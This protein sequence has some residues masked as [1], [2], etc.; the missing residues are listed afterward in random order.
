MALIFSDAL[1]FTMPED[2][3]TISWAPLVR[4]LVALQEP[5]I[6]SE[7]ERTVIRALLDGGW[8]LTGPFNDAFSSVAPELFA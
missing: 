3:S 2:L 8:S 4:G 1:T 5:F 6:S 7:Q